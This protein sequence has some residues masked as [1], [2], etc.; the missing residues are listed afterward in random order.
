MAVTQSR[1]FRLWLPLAAS[2][3]MMGCELPLLTVF[4][5]RL[6]DPEVNLA[7]YGS[8]AFPIAL[9]IEGPIIML[10]AAST[11]LSKCRESYLRLRGYMRTM[12]FWLTALHIAI[13]FTPLYDLVARGFLGAPEE[14]VEPGRL[15][16][17]LLT[18]WT[19]S[20]AYRRFQ[21][22]VL[23]RAG[24]SDAVMKGTL[25]RVLAL[26]GTLACAAALGGIPGVAVG[27]SAVALAVLAEA[28]WIGRRVRPILRETIYKAPPSEDDLDLRAFARFYIPLAVTPLITLF[29]QPAGSAAMSRMPLPLLSLAAWPAVHGLAFLVRSNGF[30]FNEVVVALAGEP[31]GIPQLRIFARRLAAALVG[32]M[33]LVALTPLAAFWYGSVS[34]LSPE[35]VSLCA[36][37]TLIA[38]VMP[39]YQVYQSLYQGLLVH[40][41]RTRAV[42]EAVALYALLA[43]VGLAIGTQF[44]TMTGVHF[45]LLV[46]VTCGLMQTAW[47]R[48][49]VSQS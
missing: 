10:L 5:A 8:V 22:G 36:T 43:V 11:A 14:V 42:T 13:A 31:D 24:Q 7:A 25:V 6:A 37:A 27:A 38:V 19:A 26:V 32:L 40:Q 29:I 1:I 41:K 35:L 3:M 48:R 34:G 15:G 44:A 39:G 2:W 46:F 49:R 23:I 30:A 28:F 17:R 9:V 47:L 12:A 20:I 45:A 4:V 21:Q 33:A 18:P 16:L